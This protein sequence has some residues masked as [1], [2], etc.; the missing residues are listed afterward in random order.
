MASPRQI[1]SAS[2]SRRHLVKLGLALPVGYA[3]NILLP[4]HST[5]A[6]SAETDPFAVKPIKIEEMVV[7]SAIVGVTT[8]ADLDQTQ[9]V[10]VDKLDELTWRYSYPSKIASRPNIVI[11]SEDIA[12]FKRRTALGRLPE[13][14]FFTDILGATENILSEHYYHATHARAWQTYF[15]GSKGFALVANKN[16]SEVFELFGFSPMSPEDYTNQWAHGDY[17]SPSDR[18]LPPPGVLLGTRE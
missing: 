13:L 2:L 14:Q 9:P 5:F 16:T 11:T 4:T 8:T 1:E 15:W 7:A 17:P 6:Q 18:K 3:A 12:V 10:G